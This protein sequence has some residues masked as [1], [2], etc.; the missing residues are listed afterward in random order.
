MCITQWKA[1]RTGRC[2]QVQPEGRSTKPGPPTTMMCRSCSA[3]WSRNTKCHLD[4]YA[5]TTKCV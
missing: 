4:E 1:N 5:N 3:P 2:P